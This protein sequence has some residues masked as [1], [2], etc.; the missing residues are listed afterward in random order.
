MHQLSTPLV[1][2]SKVAPVIL[3]PPLSELLDPPAGLDVT[4]AGFK[5]AGGWNLVFTSLL[6]QVSLQRLSLGL[7][8][9]TDQYSQSCGGSIH[10][11]STI[12]NAAHCVR[13]VN[14]ASMLIVA[15]E[16]ASTAYPRKVAL[17][18]IAL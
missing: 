17:N 9:T 12:L 3:P 14:P 1:Y 16:R 6:F 8:E 4:I 2:I 5:D 10:D 11:D 7:S 13:G 15:E 18:R